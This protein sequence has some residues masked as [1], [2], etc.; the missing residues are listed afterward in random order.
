[1]VG[2]A[3][4][5]QVRC[6]EGDVTPLA[7][8]DGSRERSQLDRGPL[9]RRGQRLIP[10]PARG[11][12]PNRA[13][14]AHGSGSTPGLQLV[15]NLVSPGVLPGRLRDRQRAFQGGFHHAAKVQLRLPSAASRS[16]ARRQVG[17][18]RAE[19]GLRP[20]QQTA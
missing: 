7:A 9:E 11:T 10:V 5:L 13:G 2:S 19:F 4:R 3:A 1:M 17:A 12:Q 16:D 8:A 15:P 6:Q 20:R 14:S 18:A